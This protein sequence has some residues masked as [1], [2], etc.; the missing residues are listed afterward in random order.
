VLKHEKHGCDGRVAFIA[1]KKLGN[2][3]WRNRAKRRMRA[4]CRDLKK[5]WPG[6]DVVFLAKSR[7]LTSSYTK[8]LVSCNDAITEEGLWHENVVNSDD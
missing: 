3:V 7:I 1:G 5:T 2:A 8:V 6:Y 4:I